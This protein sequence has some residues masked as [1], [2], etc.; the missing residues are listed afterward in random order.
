MSKSSSSSQALIVSRL[1]EETIDI[2]KPNIEYNDKLYTEVES[3][4]SAPVGEQPIGSPYGDTLLHLLYFLIYTADGRELLED[5]EPSAADASVTLDQIRA[6]LK[7][8]LTAQFPALR[9]DLL[10]V[11]IDAHFAAGEYVAAHVANDDL[12]KKQ[13]Q[14]IYHQKL[15]AILGALH[16]DAM[17]HEFSLGW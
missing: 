13:Q 9:Q 6:R 17:G 15:L 14:A 1:Y 7:A 12:K 4:T 2:E 11:V 10:D 16:D 3:S 8:A 5:N